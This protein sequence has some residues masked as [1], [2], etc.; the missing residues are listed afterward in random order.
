MSAGVLFLPVVR[1]VHTDQPA[2]HL[3]FNL[4][5][6]DLRLPDSSLA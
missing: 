6:K 3:Q 1:R 2:S 4:H 5:G